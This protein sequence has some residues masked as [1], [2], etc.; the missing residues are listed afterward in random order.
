M[1]T[2]ARTNQLALSNNYWKSPENPGDGKYPRPNDAPTGNIRG[3]SSQRE[4][5]NGTYIRI[6]NI[7]LSYV[8]PES[9]SKKLKLNSA[10][11]TSML[12]IL[13]FLQNTLPATGAQATA[14]VHDSSYRLNDYPLPKSVTVG[15]NVG[16]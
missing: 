2:R 16:F 12:P 3:E 10:R 8:L 7:T 1:S 5:D 9:I 6:N 4:I 14:E 13:S 11:F 15:L